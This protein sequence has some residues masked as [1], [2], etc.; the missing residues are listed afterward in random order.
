MELLL[1]IL[2]IIVALSLATSIASG[3]LWLFFTLV[4]YFSERR[5]R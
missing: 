2:F 4:A 3:M 5:Y 1:C